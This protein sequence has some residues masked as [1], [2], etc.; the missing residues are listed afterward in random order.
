MDDGF[1]SAAP[2]TGD[3]RGLNQMYSTLAEQL[4]NQFTS[5]SMP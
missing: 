3:E 1:A 4:V 2:H 5:V